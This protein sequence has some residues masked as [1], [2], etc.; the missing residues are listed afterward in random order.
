[1]VSRVKYPRTPHLPWSPGATNDDVRL[2]SIDALL[3]RSIVVTEK[4]DGENTTLYCDGLHARS[5]DSAHH[6]SRAWVKALQA[7]VGPGI[8]KGW[9]VCGENLYARHSLPYDRLRSYFLVFSIWDDQNRCLDWDQ[10]R[11]WASLLELHLV[12]V[13]YEGPATEP[14]L[15]QLCGKLD[16]QRQ[17]GLV[18]R[19]REG[20]G[21]PEF[22]ERVAKWVR[23][24]HVTTADHWMS[25]PVIPNEVDH[26]P[27][28]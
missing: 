28:F 7:Q 20:F 26:E 22:G 10:T 8:P 11:D 12:P 6:P 24:G 13:L 27:S 4:M 15:R 3:G 2:S 19:S 5:L 17:E 9:R 25:A 23:K 21:Y 18:V 1:M 14:L 16:L